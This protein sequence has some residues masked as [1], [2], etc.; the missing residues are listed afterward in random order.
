MRFLFSGVVRNRRDH[1]CPGERRDRIRRHTEALHVERDALREARDTELGR[2]VVDLSEV[3]DQ[4][5]RRRHVDVAA[6]LLVLEMRCG[7][8]RDVEHAAQV[9]VVDRVELG[10][11]HLVEHRVAQDAGIVD[12]HVDAA[13]RIERILDD[14]VRG[15][16]V[17]DVAHAGNRL[18]AATADFVDDPTRD[19]R[20]R[21]PLPA[22]VTPTSLTTTLAPDVA[23]SLAISAP[24]PLPAPVMTI[25]LPSSTCASL[26]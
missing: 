6:A 4:P 20:D 8:A 13:V 22:G 7:G 5:A 18:A 25:T 15:V 24:M 14:A 26:P 9:H 16:P 23:A 3:A 17:R 2:A 11:R 19:G 12:Q 1:A 10:A 21:R